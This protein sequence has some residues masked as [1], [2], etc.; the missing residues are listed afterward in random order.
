MPRAPLPQHPPDCIAPTSPT[1]YYTTCL[2]DCP[3]GTHACHPFALPHVCM[4]GGGNGKGEFKVGCL[5]VHGWG[6]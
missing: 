4:G 3:S 1:V 2:F 5:C 6:G